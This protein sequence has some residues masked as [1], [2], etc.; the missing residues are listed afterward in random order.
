MSFTARGEMEV[1]IRD[2]QNRKNIGFRN[3][4]DEYR[5]EEERATFRGDSRA[6]S[7][8]DWQIINRSGFNTP[9]QEDIV[10]EI[11]RRIYPSVKNYII[12]NSDW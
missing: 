10:R 12:Q 7:P 2:I 3:F 11:Y 5:W 9:R 6:L 1:Q 4:R 8:G